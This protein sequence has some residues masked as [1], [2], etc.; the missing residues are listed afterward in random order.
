VP[1][2][3]VL[4]LEARGPGSIVVKPSRPVD[5][6]LASKTIY[7]RS[8]S[9]YFKPLQLVNELNKRAEIGAWGLSFVDD[10]RVA[11]LILTIDHVPF[12]YKY[13][14]IIAH[15]RTGVIVASGSRIIWDGNLGAPDM[16][17]RVVE[18][19][20]EVRAQTPTKPEAATEKS[21]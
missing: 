16:A 6:L 17:E 4:P 21:K 19:L 18:K 10:V 3:P 2:R 13:T 7:V 1:Q 5:L 15:Q 11:D 14:F 8:Y 9:T 20:K 12:T